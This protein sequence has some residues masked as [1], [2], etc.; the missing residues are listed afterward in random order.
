MKREGRGHSWLI[1]HG[2]KHREATLG[3]WLIANAECK[4][5]RIEPRIT[6][7]TQIQAIGWPTS[8]PTIDLAA[9]ANSQDDDLVAFQIEYHSVVANPEPVGPECRVD[10]LLGVPE[11]ILTKPFY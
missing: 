2:T 5:T 9:V 3:S 6:Q 7:I 11:W 8:S 4:I 1:A 10:E